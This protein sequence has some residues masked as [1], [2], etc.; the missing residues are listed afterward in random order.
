VDFRPREN[1]FEVGCRGDHFGIDGLP[2]ARP[3]GS[4]I[5][6]VFRRKERQVTT[7]TI[8]DACLMILV[9]GVHEWPLGLLVPQDAIGLWGKDLLPLLVGLNEFHDWTD[10]W[11]LAHREAPFFSENVAKAVILTR[12][13]PV[14]RDAPF[15]KR[16]SPFAL[17]R[18]DAWYMTLFARAL[19]LRDSLVLRSG[20]LATGWI[21]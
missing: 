19:Q 17:P 13:P 4:A 21:S 3:A 11:L 7:G 6:L 8:V 5:E 18:R 16:R 1:K 15:T 14:R 2:E 12:P 9:H 20:D 10:L